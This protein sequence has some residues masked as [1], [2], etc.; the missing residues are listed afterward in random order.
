MKNFRAGDVIVEIQNTP[1]RSPDELMTRIAAD[2]K[3]GHKVVVMLVSRGGNLTFVAV[4][5]GA[6]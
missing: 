3:A 6:G 4:R 5:I 2:K 1:V